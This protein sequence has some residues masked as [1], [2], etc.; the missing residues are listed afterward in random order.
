[1]DNTA[2]ASPAWGKF[3]EP[4]AG[5]IDRDWAAGVPAPEVKVKPARITPQ[6]RPVS[7]VVWHRSSAVAYCRPEVRPV[8]LPRSA[9]LDPAAE[10]LD[11]GRAQPVL[12]ARDVR[13]PLLLVRVRHALDERAPLGVAG[14]DRHL[15]RSGRRLRHLL[16]VEAQAHL[17]AVPV[18]AVAG[19]TVVGQDRPYVFIEGDERTRGP[20][21]GGGAG[22]GR[23]RGGR[24]L[25][26]RHLDDL[27]SVRP[28]GAIVD[29][30]H[31]RLDLGRRERFGALWH[32]LLRI[33]RY[34]PL[35][36]QAALPI[37]AHYGPARVPALEQAF[38]G[39]EPETALRPGRA[40]AAD[41]G[42]GQ[43]GLDV[44]DEVERGVGRR[45]GRAPA[46]TSAPPM[47]TATM[48]APADPRTRG[49]F[50]PFSKMTA[51]RT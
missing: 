12:A 44:P 1:V 30:A 49:L 39:V 17:P 47:L 51:C 25:R 14:D 9:L 7:L 3:P 13:H 41:A 18:G 26:G 24:R 5:R 21:G 20:S 19:V 48:A 33:V 46:K 15:S 8:R 28:G 50:I 42:G 22:E 6:P 23:R 32:P 37:A 29:P 2:I 34:Q 11:L 45:R 10:R 38:P 35:V 27:H 31:Q 36:E 43:D 4:N 40:M 16:A